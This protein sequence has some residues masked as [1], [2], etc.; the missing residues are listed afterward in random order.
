MFRVWCRAFVRAL[1]VDLKLHQKNLNPV[2]E[3]YILIA[4]HPSAFEDVG[5]PALFEVYSLAKIEVKKW[6]IVGR[7]SEAAGTLYVKRESKESRHQAAECIKQALDE[8]KNIALYPEGGCK[9]K[10]IFESFRYGAFD[11]SLK[12]GVPVLPVFLH[13]EAQDDFEWR[14]PHTLIDKLF[15]FLNTKNNTVNYYVF[16]AIDPAQFDNKEEYTDYVWNLYIKWQ[17]K[18]LE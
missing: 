18:Y 9:G 14:S 15:H 12:T 11:V 17:K 4:N 6:W 3:Q 5:I 1:D 10:R 8:G 7:M 2:P 13:Y 16:D